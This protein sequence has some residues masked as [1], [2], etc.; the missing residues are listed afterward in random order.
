MN[1][2]IREITR[3][4]KLPNISESQRKEVTRWILEA[5]N[6][7]HR[8]QQ[9]QQLQLQ[10]PANENK[11][12]DS[13]E[14][15]IIATHRMQTINPNKPVLCAAAPSD[16]KTSLCDTTTA[17]LTES[18]QAPTYIK[19][20]QVFAAAGC[21]KEIKTTIAQFKRGSYTSDEVDWIMQMDTKSKKKLCKLSKGEQDAVLTS[22]D[23][24]NRCSYAFQIR[25]CGQLEQVEPGQK[26]KKNL[27]QNNCKCSNDVS[28][29]TT[30]SG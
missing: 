5:I 14:D 8:G 7:G 15:S 17:F 4:A 22:K 18:K 26:L 11:E 27:N 2:I 16:K 13:T 24:T 9:E 20:N 19:Q 10:T 6:K 1:T 28:T 25:A 30:C 21:F 3:R 23:T 12:K 29:A